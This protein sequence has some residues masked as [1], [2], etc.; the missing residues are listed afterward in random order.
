MHSL[1]PSLKYF[2]CPAFML[3]HWRAPG[4]CSAGFGEEMIGYGLVRLPG[5]KGPCA[6]GFAL[7]TCVF[8]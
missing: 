3:Q 7:L 5:G 1:F 4:W 6:G 8:D 2:V